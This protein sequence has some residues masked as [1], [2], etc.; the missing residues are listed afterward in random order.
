MPNRPI[1]TT[2]KDTPPISSLAP[3]VRRKVPVIV[4]M[5][6]VDNANPI[7]NEMIVLSGAELPMPIK[8]Q[9]ARK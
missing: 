8:A 4:S 9:K 1:T 3:K 6:T 2:R 7:S 5:P